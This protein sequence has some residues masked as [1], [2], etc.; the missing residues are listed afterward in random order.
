MLIS[1]PKLNGATFPDVPIVNGA[2][3]DMLDWGYTDVYWGSLFP[4]S[5]YERVFF[6]WVFR[7]VPGALV[8]LLTFSNPTLFRDFNFLYL[9]RNLIG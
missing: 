6:C 9:A 2:T 4:I 7:V 1:V 5:Y 8:V 3:E